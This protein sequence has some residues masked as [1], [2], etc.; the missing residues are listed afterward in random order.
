MRK[1]L[2]F[3]IVLISGILLTG[4]LFYLQILDTSYATLSVNNAIKRVYDYPQRG[5]I[6]DRNGNLLVSNQPSYDVMVIPREVKAFDTTEF[7]GLLKM[8]KEALKTRLSKA[9][10]YSP[11]LPSIVIPQLTKS[12]YAYLQEKMRKYEGFYIQKRSLRDYQVDFGANFLGYIAEVNRSDIEDNP[13]YQSG[14]LRGRTGVE[15]QYEE[16]LRGVKGVKYIQKDRFNRDIGAYKNG[17]LDTLPQPGKDLTLTIDAELQKY[18]EELMVNKRGGI[19]A[20]EPSTGEILALISAP[21]YDPSLLVGRQ[22][23]A[24]FTKL[25]YDT[26]SK[27]LFDRSLQAEYPPGSPFKTLNALIALQ[28]NVVDT[29]ESFACHGGYYYGSR[30]RK[31]G[32]HHHPSPLSMIPGIA[33]SCNAYFA[34]VYRRVIEKYDTPQ[35]G[36]DKW[37]NHLASFGLG[38]YMGTDLPTG[39]PGYIPDS[40]YYNRAY[41]YPKYKWFSTATISN[42][43]GQGEVSL[44]PIQLAN[45]TATIANRGW[46][47]TPHI[48][49][50]IEDQTELIPEEY[51]TKNVTTIDPVNFE[52]VVEGMFGAYNYGTA[53]GVK[54]PGIEI[55]GKTGTAENYTKIDGKR[56]Q[57][58]DHSIFV[59]FA[60]KDNPKIAIAVFVENGY[61][62]GRYGGKIASLMIEKHI[63]GEITRT[64]LEDWILTH[65]LE[66][67]YAK[68][69]SGKP[70]PINDGKKISG[71]VEKPIL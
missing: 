61:W 3:S 8:T 19:I 49:K 23:S 40:D 54:I 44:T 52:P 22:R 65:S 71:K 50:K 57:L 21:N 45:V 64:D 12:E 11:R 37:H 55:C 56:Q 17:T 41:K 47:Y 6:Y 69:L 33:N 25:W 30:G 62:G 5:H 38:Q 31:L 16:T 4:R 48:V 70:F 35:E 28:E 27:P 7:C 1:I 34:N 60:P 26:I 13:Y 68:P 10:V 14:D 43:I 20:I 59:A 42:S 29:Q 63:K 32:C 9:R 67:E 36:M 51:R 66:E 2:L 18:G 39:R 53:A 24:N 58:T 46:Y 15:R